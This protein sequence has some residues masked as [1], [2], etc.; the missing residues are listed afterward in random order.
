MTSEESFPSRSFDELVAEQSQ[1]QASKFQ[2]GNLGRLNDW[3]FDAL[4]WVPPQSSR[5]TDFLADFVP[6]DQE[7]SLEGVIKGLYQRKQAPVTWVDMGAGE[8]LIMRELATRSEM[9][10]KLEMIAVD[11]LDY[12]LRQFDKEELAML[13][14]MALGI[15]EDRTR[16]LR[17]IADIGTVALPKPADLITAVEVTQ[18]LDDPLRAVA[19]FYN[20]LADGGLMIVA[21]ASGWSNGL[22]YVGRPEERATRDLVVALDQADVSHAAQHTHDWPEKTFI[23]EDSRR[24]DEID[25]HAMHL[26]GVQKKPGTE[27]VVNTE[28]M[29]VFTE[30]HNYKWVYYQPPTAGS[31]PPV[32]VVSV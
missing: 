10:G 22:M 8:A 12:N 24:R 13:E 19:N 28:L 25:F 16:P 32:A 27:L 7:M 3:L 11:L 26:L 18:Y 2:G 30:E 31:P 17:V 21:N 23:P 29:D 15:T 20:Q 4:K 9:A 5:I 6:E 1:V 14:E